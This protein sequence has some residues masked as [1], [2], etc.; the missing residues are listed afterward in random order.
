MRAT[1]LLTLLALL[2]SCEVRSIEVR[3]MPTGLGGEGGQATGGTGGFNLGG[4]GGGGAGGTAGAGGSGGGSAGTGGGGTGGS[5]GQGGSTGGAGG[6]AC[7]LPRDE[8]CNGLDDDCDGV[9]DD[10]F[11]LQNDPANCGRCGGSCSY[12]HAFPACR[13]GQCALGSCFEGY[14]DADGRSD[15]GCECLYTNNRVEICDGADNDCDGSIDEDFDFTSDLRHC[16]GCFKTCSY[17]QAASS[18]ASGTC[19]MGACSPG[20]IDLNLE[21]RDGCEYRCTPTNGGVE[22]CDG[23]DNDCDGTI[24]RN[25]TDAG[26]ACGGM[27]GGTGECRQ[28]SRMCI[29][30]TL[31]CVGAG[32]PGTEVCD[33]KDNDCDGNTDEEDPFLGTDCYPV[34]VTGCDVNAGT[35]RGPCRL[36]SWVCSTGRLACQG[37]V[38]PVNEVC[39]NADNDCDG[40]SDEGFDKQNDPRFCGTCGTRC[41]YA[42]AIALCQSGACVRGP[43]NLGYTDA[44]GNAADG[45]EY[46]CSSEG[47]EVCDGRDNDC[48][49]RT[50]SDDSDLQYPAINFCSQLGECGKGPGGSTRYG[51]A[52]S[53][54]VCATAAGATRPDWICN[55]P[56]TVETVPGSPN[57]IVTQEGICDTKDNDCDGVSDE[58]TTNRPGTSCQESAGTGECRRSGTYRCQTNTRADTACD[59]TGVPARTPEHETCDGKDNDCDGLVDESWDNPNLAAFTKCSGLDCR[60][61]R[62]ELAQVGASYVFRYEASRVDATAASQGAGSSRPCS[63]TGVMPWTLV[64]QGQAATACQKIGMRLCTAAEWTAACKGSQSCTSEYFP[65]ACTFNQNLCNGAEKARNAAVAAGSEAMCSTQGGTTLFDMSGNVAEWTS[66]QNGMVGTKKIFILR[67][68]SFNNYEP[69]LR[70]DSSLLA[71]AEDYSFLDAGFRCCSICAPGQAECQGACVN[72]ASSNSHCGACGQACGGGTTCRNGV[73]Q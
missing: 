24:D 60:G 15:N 51:S 45:C 33:G 68:G 65:Y 3:Q 31:V 52:A 6:A 1:K 5:G 16:G 73:C 69:A 67:G 11:D 66:Q 44:N 37:M 20:Y 49:G 26:A 19:A 38:T 70:C 9:A 2:A 56:A 32:T 62:E 43:C 8:I 14:A 27:P 10:G 4:T 21:A 46:Q 57:Q 58:H 29:N 12:V 50:D 34:G 42:N 17:F 71:F 59:F 53:Y 18:C 30:G 13:A 48:D 72:L 23:Q 41:E 28:G 40:N 7:P 25:T 55:Y 61:V 36:G 47:V 64:N 39:D 54:P 35:C 22:V 63:R